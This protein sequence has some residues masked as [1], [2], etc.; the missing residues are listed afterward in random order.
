MVDKDVKQ[1]E[2]ISCIF[3]IM[4][5]HLFTAQPWREMETKAVSNDTSKHAASC[6]GVL[7]LGCCSGIK[8]YP[9]LDQAYEFSR[10]PK[11]IK[12]EAVQR[13]GFFET[14]FFSKAA[15]VSSSFM[16]CVLFQLHGKPTNQKTTK[17]KQISFKHESS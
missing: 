13:L 12:R 1:A 17:P 4:T 16:G 2:N 5:L 11:V 8:E 15:S 6:R 7:P 10:G 3:F 14:I 9:A